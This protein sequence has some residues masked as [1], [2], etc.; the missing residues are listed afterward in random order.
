MTATTARVRHQIFSSIFYA[1]H[2]TLAFD[3]THVARILVGQ[4]RETLYKWRPTKCN[5]DVDDRCN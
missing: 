2:V 3:V 4:L 1:V 5:A